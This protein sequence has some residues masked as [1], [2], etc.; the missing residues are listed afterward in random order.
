MNLRQRRRFLRESVRN[1]RSKA[2]DRPRTLR[3]PDNRVLRNE[4]YL[5]GLVHDKS[6][7]RI[8]L[9]VLASAVS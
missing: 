4:E 5:H 9:A 7:C 6:L 2:L 8:L 1:E 3:G